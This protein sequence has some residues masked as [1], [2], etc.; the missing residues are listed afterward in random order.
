MKVE[1]S[2]GS[3]LINH[4]CQWHL[5][6]KYS[7][8]AASSEECY[9]YSLKLN[10]ESCGLEH[11][12]GEEKPFSEHNKKFHFILKSERI[13]RSRV[14]QRQHYY[15]VTLPHT[16]QW[17]Q[18]NWWRQSWVIITVSISFDPL[19]PVL[20]PVSSVQCWW[21]ADINIHVRVN[22]LTGQYWIHS[23]IPMTSGYR[24]PL[25]SL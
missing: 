15:T 1:Y 24:N 6:R 11:E 7:P 20:C 4:P 17:K 14:P 16:T 13:I 22:T 21:W 3:S 9:K 19:S 2:R 8:A 18:R 23:Q 25:N 12:L 10:T 5:L